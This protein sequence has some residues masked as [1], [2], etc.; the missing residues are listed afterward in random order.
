VVTKGGPESLD[1]SRCLGIDSSLGPVLRLD[2]DSITGVSELYA[3]SI[4]NVSMHL[5]YIN[6][7]NIRTVQRLKSRMINNEPGGK[8]VGA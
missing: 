3:A 1:K 2:M 4:F 5:P 8:A 6:T 7:D